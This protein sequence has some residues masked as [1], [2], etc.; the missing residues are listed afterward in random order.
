MQGFKHVHAWLQ[1]L[2]DAVLAW[3]IALCRSARL[4]Q[5]P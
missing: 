1:Q 5:T 4:S 3:I 2:P